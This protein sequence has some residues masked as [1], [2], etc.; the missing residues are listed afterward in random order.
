MIY[1]IKSA[2]GFFSGYVAGMTGM[3]LFDSQKSEAITFT[4]P[5]EAHQTAAMLRDQYGIQCE[6][7]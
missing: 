6:V 3:P 1:R 5:V 4:N 7:I 2:S